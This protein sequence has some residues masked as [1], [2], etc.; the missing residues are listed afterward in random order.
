MSSNHPKY[1]GNKLDL[2]D[3]HKIDL[4]LKAKVKQAD[5]SYLNLMLYIKFLK[6]YMIFCFVTTFQAL[7]LNICDFN[8][9]ACFKLTNW[10]S[11]C[12][13]RF[14]I[15]FFDWSI[16]IMQTKYGLQILVVSKSVRLFRTGMR[17]QDQ[18][19]QRPTGFAF[20]EF[21]DS[22]DAEGTKKI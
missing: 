15:L 5:I 20:I 11:E 18:V 4:F 3:Y 7:L 12:V 21:E 2:N 17:N 13:M 19:A 9:I 10:I 16:Q 1:F 6:M 8:W 22:R 14:L